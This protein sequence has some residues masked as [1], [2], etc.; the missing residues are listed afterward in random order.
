MSDLDWWK[1]AI[2]YELYVD[3]FA[4]NFQSLT[5]KLDYFTYL[6]VNTLW[7]LPHYPSPMIDGGYDISDY[8]NVRT[9]QGTLSDFDEFIKIAHSKGLKV[10][11]DLV[12]NHTS[13][14]HPWFVEARA[15]KDN[16][17]RDWYLWSDSSDRFSQAFVHFADIK[18]KNWIVNQFTGDYYYATFYKEQPDLNWDNP[19]VVEA[20]YQVMDFWL[21]K[22]VDGFR[23]DAVARLI[24]REGT[25]CFA[26]PETHETLK[27]IRLHIDSKYQGIVL[28]AETG[29]WPD[30][31]RNFFGTGDEC[32][33]V[34]HFPL[35]VKLLSAISTKDLSGISDIWRW[36]GPIPDNCGW[37][38]FLTNHDSVDL[39]F[40]TNEEEK[41]RLIQRA[42]PTGQFT[43]YDSQSFGARLAE[44]CQGNKDDLLWVTKEL[45]SQPGVPIIYYGN[46]IG[47]RNSPLSEKPHDVRAYVRG[48]FDW[49]EAE[50]QKSDPSSSLNQVHNLILERQSVK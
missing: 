6:G 37:A 29:G 16:P 11:T 22:G 8:Q 47:M 28:M 40:L 46:E 44:I 23:L 26:L 3:K 7:I 48:N 21:D 2:I 35:A 42:D 1:K 31:A 30:E 13:D 41:Q 34:I 10:I 43:Q 18:S 49:S 9:D 24:K 5:K 17:K 32:H 19:E 25:N 33:L 14:Q 38:V 39:F 36:T 27:K 15:S 45:L 20:M 50:K 4:G 12:L